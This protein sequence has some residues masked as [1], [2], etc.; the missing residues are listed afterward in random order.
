VPVPVAV[1]DCVW[2]AVELPDPENPTDTFCDGVTSC[3]LLRVLVRD[4]EPVD[5][6][7]WVCE[8][9]LLSVCERERVIEGVCVSFWL[10][11]RDVE[12]KVALWERVRVPLCVS[13]ALCVR[14][15]LRVWLAVTDGDCE[16]EMTDVDASGQHGQVPEQAALA[17]FS[18]SPYFPA[19]QAF[20]PAPKPPRQK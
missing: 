6:A 7:L 18:V 12:M 17:R 5:E 4:G 10:G 14:V 3:D 9:V 1:L 19:A 13:E 11:V 2:L 20:V 16:Q 8:G 15:A